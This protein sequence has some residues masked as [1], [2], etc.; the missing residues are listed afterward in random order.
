MYELTPLVSTT[1]Q[2]TWSVGA[3]S[4]KQ[5]RTWLGQRNTV[6]LVMFRGVAYIYECVDELPHCEHCQFRVVFTWESVTPLTS[7][8]Q[9]HDQP[10]RYLGATVWC[11]RVYTFSSIGAS[12]TPP[13]ARLYM[14]S[15][16]IPDGDVFT[17]TAAS[18]SPCRQNNRQNRKRALC[19]LLRHGHTGRSLH[20]RRL[21]CQAWW[22]A[23]T[24]WGLLT[25]DRA[26]TYESS[27]RAAGWSLDTA[28]ASRA[29]PCACR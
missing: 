18:P 15:T 19:R 10:G 21:R 24:V 20:L 23:G 17:F 7:S 3:T 16:R 26:G 13:G 8:R 28:A 22:S 14:S 11:G 4:A 25:V 9:I 29:R 27:L 12:L 6:V 2:V 5:D 1:T